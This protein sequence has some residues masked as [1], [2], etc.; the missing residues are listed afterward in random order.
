MRLIRLLKNDLARETVTWVEKNFIS[1][2]QAKSICRHYG[3]EYDS[4]QKHSG[5]YIVLVVLA[6]LFIGFALITLIGAN[7]DEIPRSIRMAGL[8]ALTLSVQGT[9][10]H[11][12]RKDKIL[13]SAIF[14]F[15]GNFVYG[16]SIMLIAQVYH[17]G[18]YIPNGIFWW[19]LGS[20]PFAIVLLNPWLMFGSSF[21]A[22]VWFLLESSL[23]F[24]PM[25]FPI[26]I[27]ASLYVLA[28]A[29][30]NVFLFLL[31][32]INIGLWFEVSLSWAWLE[33]DFLL[34]W[35]KE[36]F[37]VSMAFFIFLYSTSQWIYGY[38]NAKM[39]EYGTLLNLWILCV[40]LIT[41]L[42]LTFEYPWEILLKSNWH[43]LLPMSSL[44]IAFLI[45]SIYFSAKT[46]KLKIV[47]PIILLYVLSS[48]TVILWSNEAYAVV[49]QI[50]YNIILVI[51]GV[52][53]IITGFSRA[54]PHYFF[55]GVITIVLVALMRYIDLVGGYMGASILFIALA[56][57]LLLIAGYWK[58]Y[59][60]ARITTKITK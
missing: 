16:A 17:L 52:R 34:H 37:L 28:R 36:H 12:Y 58:K 20:L 27:F 6:C 8:L 25:W 53:L 48:L 9:A 43:T 26:F 22:L 42:V 24:Y 15:L 14:F 4:I 30:S 55:L 2:E 32:L 56:I 46:K 57:L 18:E 45:P 1:K 11:Y 60:L 38:A 51:I 29:K 59:T 13:K 50:A 33:G 49:F 31:T 54:I 23:N 10:L 47:L 7:W 3:I 5:G 44:V 41:M 19:A 35:Q 40:S 39:K 21:L